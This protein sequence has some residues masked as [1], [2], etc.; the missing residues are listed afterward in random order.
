MA[1]HC[2]EEG[3]AVC[4]AAGSCWP[5]LTDILISYWLRRKADDV[6]EWEDMALIS[7][8]SGFS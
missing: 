5:Q 8:T 2:S 4:V 6:S 1:A 7:P 3:Q